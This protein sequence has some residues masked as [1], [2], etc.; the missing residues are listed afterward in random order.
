M[1]LVLVYNVF[2]GIELLPYAAR[3]VREHV[4]Y[5]MVHYQK[6]N[7]YGK[8]LEE[9]PTILLNQLL[10]EG[11]IDE[12]RLFDDFIPA[13][14]GDWSVS[15]QHEKRKRTI[16]K[17]W[18]RQNEFTHYIESDIDEFYTPEQF[19]AAKKLIEDHNYD[20]TS[21]RLYDY[22]LSPTLM[23]EN[24]NPINVP[25]IC[26]LT[27]ADNRGFG[28]IHVDPTRTVAGY[29]GNHYHFKND[30]LMCHHM[31]TV[32]K[33]LIMKYS[34]TS[35]RYLKYNEIDKLVEILKTSKNNEEVNLQGMIFPDNFKVIKVEN[36]FN[37]PE[38]TFNTTSDE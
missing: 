37:I 18:A 1:K 32:R 5:I 29:S 22:F 17:L 9:D 25:F 35:R 34:S 27:T 15:K 28:D 7:W 16:S 13:A 12:V 20:S 38:F 6:K 3:A 33:D 19:S 10:N 14:F 24:P 21:C 31:E 2:D 26:S 30:E 23:K 4:D 11:L 8:E 36:I